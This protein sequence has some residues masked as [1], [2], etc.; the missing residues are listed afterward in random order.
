VK[1]QAV[2]AKSQRM[3][4]VGFLLSGDL[5]DPDKNLTQKNA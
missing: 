4:R 1:Q 2:K 5:N 3:K